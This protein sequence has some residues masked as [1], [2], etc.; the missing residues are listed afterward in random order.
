V[1]LDESAR[2]IEPGTPVRFIPYGS[3]GL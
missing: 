2:Q 1:E 3:F